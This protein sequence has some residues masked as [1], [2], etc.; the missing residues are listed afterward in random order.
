MRFVSQYEGY[1]AQIRVNRQRAIDGGGVEVLT[2]GLYVQFVPVHSGGMLYE[3]ERLAALEHFNFR[4]QTQDIGEAIPT[5]PVQR[6]SICDT[7]EMA[8]QN[9]WSA[10]DKELVERRL[11]EIA[12][13]VPQ[14]V[15]QVASTPLEAPFPNYDRYEGDPTA[16]IVKL[17][18]D[19]HDV[20][21]V[22]GY[23]QT[24]GPRRPELIEKLQEAVEVRQ[25]MELTA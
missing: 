12:M 3:N 23:E 14:E 25:Q 8:V 2:P 5:D 6:L 18:E 15:L 21:Y 24:F 11:S 9:G 16:L 10:E 1:G 22:L 19:G 20:E 17:I 4:G 7:D 13:T